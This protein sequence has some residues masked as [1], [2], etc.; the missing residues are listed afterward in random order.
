M[1][2]LFLF[3]CHTSS[4]SL[5]LFPIEH[6]SSHRSYCSP[7]RKGKSPLVETSSGATKAFFFLG[8]LHHTPFSRFFSTQCDYIF[9]VS[10]YLL[11]QHS[12]FYLYFL[13]LEKRGIA[14]IFLGLTMFL[15]PRFLPRSIFPCGASG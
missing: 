5:Y 9:L 8:F 7:N 3:S 11:Y 6:L 13:F 14:R 1:N 10:D 4:P 12:F 15:H 2:L